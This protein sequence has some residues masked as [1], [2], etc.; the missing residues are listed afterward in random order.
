MGLKQRREREK[1]AMRQGILE[2]ARHLARQEGWSAVTIR[3]I[4]EQIEYSP[5]IVY[6]Y[7]ASKEDLL[8]E[9]LREGFRLL[10]AAMQRAFDSTEDCEEQVLRSGEAYCRFAHVYPEL[11]QVMYGLG[12]VPLDSQERMLAAQEVCRI[13][14]KALTA[15]A[16]SK[17][18]TLDDPDEAVE[19]LLALLHGLVSLYAVDRSQQ[20]DSRAERL[21]RRTIQSLL[22]AWSLS[23]Q[24]N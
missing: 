23:F 19:I 1:Q 13:T 5:P 15:W 4:A 20:E 16:Q 24:A 6:E 11:Y 18:V 22:K 17:G 12:G 10:A 8:L 14:L 2:A 9:L 3:K 21:A 7:F